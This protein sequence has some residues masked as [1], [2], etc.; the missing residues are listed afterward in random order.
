MIGSR[1]DVVVAGAGPAGSAAAR[2]LARDGLRVLLLEEHTEVGM[3]LHCSGLVTPRT[4][5]EAGVGTDLVLHRVLGAHVFAPSGAQLT[6][7]D[8]QTRA[9]VID[10]VGLDRALVAEA[11]KQ[12]AHLEL[13]ARVVSVERKG[14]GLDAPV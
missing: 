13:G 14:S 7:G 2:L 10:R 11:Q 4:L 5:D 12:G 3:P 1:Y 6:L 9:L 8:G